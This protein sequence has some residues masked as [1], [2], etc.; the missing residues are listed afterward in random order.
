[1]SAGLRDGIDILI[2]GVT[3]N[4]HVSGS[5]ARAAGHLGLVTSTVDTELAYGGN[6][7]V[8]KVLWHLADRRPIR[9]QSFSRHVRELASSKSPRVLLTVGQAPVTGDVI[10]EIRATGVVC[11][12]FSTDDPFNPA[13]SSDWHRKDLSCYEHVFTPRRDNMEQLEK[14]ARG[15]VHYLPFGYDADLF[16]P[17]KD[18]PQ[19]VPQILF[20]G[21][22]D[23][24][25][26]A[27]FAS[28]MRTGLIPTF[29]GGYWERYAHTRSL[30]LGL[31]DA[32]TI[33]DLTTA[34]A[35]NICLVRRA[36]RDGHVMRSFEIPAVGGAMLVE[37]TA[38]HRAFFGRDGQY[39]SYFATP[40]EA[41]QKC[42][43][44]LE[45]PVETRRMAAHLHQFVTRGG[46]SYTDRLRT[47]F[48]TCVR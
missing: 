39:V 47:I 13:V 27:F 5:F 33:R 46:H 22:A 31:K 44:L 17:S 11:A 37:D 42:T 32:A 20:V 6:V 21:G 16:Y 8:R 48:E 19:T 24:D 1:M 7:I 30:T 35:V 15:R 45:H 25:R 41:A 38:E 18:L 23:A 14:I 29:V 43:G 12:N 10:E 36:N 4:T 26:A 3:G 2:V 28:F 34:A 40:E 9:L